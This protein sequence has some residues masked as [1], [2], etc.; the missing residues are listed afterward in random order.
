MIEIWKSIKEYNG[1]YKVSNS[2]FIKRVVPCAKATA[3]QIG[4]TE[5]SGYKSVVLCKNKIKAKF[6]IHRL[7]ALYF[8][9]K[10]PKNKQC[11]NHIDGNPT[12][13]SVTNLE[14]CSPKE[15]TRHAIETGLWKNKGI[16][17]WK[18]RLKEK[19]IKY[20]REIYKTGKV[21]QTYLAKKYKVTQT[22]ICSIINKKLW[23]HL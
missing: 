21:T 7:V 10:P 3:R 18:S 11:V 2:G 13:N 22:A 5:S 17:H 20:I 23:K 9:G 8:I 14:Y 1:V 15:N 12:N 6:R 4:F 19:D 16:D